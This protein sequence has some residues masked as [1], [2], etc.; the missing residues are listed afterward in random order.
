MPSAAAAAAAATAAVTAQ[1]T[2]RLQR[3]AY[4]ISIALD[5]QE[6]AQTGIGLASPTI[7]Q[8]Q[9]VYSDNADC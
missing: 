5:S 8:S 1:H 4:E 2:Y 6:T 9:T 3:P 7:L